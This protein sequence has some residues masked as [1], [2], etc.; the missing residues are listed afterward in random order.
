MRARPSGR[1]LDVERLAR[2]GLDERIAEL[3]RQGLLRGGGAIAAAGREGPVFAHAFGAAGGG[4][5]M[6]V[7]HRFLLTSVT[8]PFI[9]MQVLQLAEAGHLDLRAPVAAAIPEFGQHGKESVTAWH[10]LTHTS[11]IDLVA[12]TAEGPSAGLT[13]AQ[14]LANALAAALN[15]VPGTRFEYCSPGFW[16]LAEL[17]TRLSGLDYTEHLRVA[18]AEPLGMADTR[19]EPQEQLPERWAGADAL[20]E[21]HL[22]EQVRRVAYPAGG[23]VSTVSDLAVLGRTLLAGGVRDGARLLGPATLDAMATKAIDGWYQGREVAWGLGWELGGPGDFRSERTLF[24]YGGSGT[25]LW[26]DLDYELVVAFL[27]TS[28]HLDWRVYGQVA[29]AVYG[30]VATGSR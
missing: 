22:A 14:H 23:M 18:I 11:G 29:N 25:G 12:N 16:V 27:T 19:Y 24:H 8:K 10:L 9:A 13:G 1:G 20:H 2:T 21:P 5:P 17:I 15:F 3:L 28:W 4:E 6:R 30:A 7:D 26:V